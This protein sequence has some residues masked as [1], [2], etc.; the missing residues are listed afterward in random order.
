MRFIL[1]FNIGFMRLRST[2]HKTIAGKLQTQNQRMTDFWK[3]SD[4]APNSCVKKV[5]GAVPP[6]EFNN[7]SNWFCADWPRVK[8]FK[9]DLYCGNMSSNCCKDFLGEV[10]IKDN[11]SHWLADDMRIALHEKL[12]QWALDENNVHALHW[13]WQQWNLMAWSANMDSLKLHNF[14]P[15]I[16]SVIV[17]FD[18]SKQTN[19]HN[20]WH[21]RT[22]MY[23]HLISNSVASP[24]LAFALH[25]GRIKWRATKVH[26]CQKMQRMGL[27]LNPMLSNCNLLLTGMRKR[28]KPTC[29]SLGSPCMGFGRK[30]CF[31][32][33][34]EPP[35]HHLCQPLLGAGSG[36]FG[37]GPWLSL[38]FWKWRRSA[39]RQSLNWIGSNQLRLWL[40]STTFQP[41]QS[42]EQS[43]CGESNED[44]LW[45]V[46]GW[47]S[48]LHQDLAQMSGLHCA[49]QEC[50]DWPNGESSW[51][52]FQQCYHSSRAWPSGGF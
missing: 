41:G 45:R 22:S 42:N 36:A 2:T 50:F 51:P 21:K 20:G 7:E 1:K 3:E 38:A 13:T 29:H 25:F 31:M 23:I 10:K 9:E 44:H 5:V 39:F 11:G 30:W 4:K 32:Q 19:R 28:W 17:K 46:P 14:R 12:L 47:T 34:Q 35:W 43:I 48:R 49:L 40:S 27:V 33:H 6:D 15:R 52:R 8:P 37:G 16:D 18:K 24:D 26:F